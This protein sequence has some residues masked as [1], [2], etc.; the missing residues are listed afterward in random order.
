LALETLP[1]Q[2]AGEFYEEATRGRNALHHLPGALSCC[3][4]IVWFFKMLLLTSGVYMP[5]EKFRKLR[6]FVACPGDV[7]DEKKRLGK[8]IEVSNSTRRVMDSS[9]NSSN[10]A[11]P[12]LTSEW[13]KKSSL[14]N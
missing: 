9:L 6:V 1:S 11:S 12:F 13:R 10:G 3:N 4:E 2:R 5:S 7:E 8:V 14:A